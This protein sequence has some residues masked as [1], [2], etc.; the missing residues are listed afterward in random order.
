MA[1]NDTVTWSKLN[2]KGWGI[3]GTGFV[4]TWYMGK[5]FYISG[6]DREVLK[7]LPIKNPKIRVP[8]APKIGQSNLVELGGI[9][10]QI[11][12]VDEAVGG[13]NQKVGSSN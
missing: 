2:D 3:G 8:Q 1:L 6:K 13:G 10:E 11:G 5:Q 9:F 4:W 12:G 7:I